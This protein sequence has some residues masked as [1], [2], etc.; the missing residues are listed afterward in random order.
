[1]VLE[2]VGEEVCMTKGSEGNGNKAKR[3]AIEPTLLVTARHR[4]V[5]CL[6]L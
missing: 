6:L 5:G 3:V 2:K 4:K 1:M